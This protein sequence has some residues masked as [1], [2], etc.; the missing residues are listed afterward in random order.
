MSRETAELAGTAPDAKMRALLE[1][2]SRDTKAIAEGRSVVGSAGPHPPW[3]ETVAQI[4][5][6]KFAIERDQERA[7]QLGAQM[8]AAQQLDRHW[9]WGRRW[10]LGSTLLTKI[11]RTILLAALASVV[12]IVGHKLGLL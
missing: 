12:A 5:E 9:L 6:L 1:D 3:E 11:V 10:I 7:R 8:E 4:A 2:V